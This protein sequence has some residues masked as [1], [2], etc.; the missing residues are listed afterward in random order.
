MANRSC[1]YS[2]PSRKRPHDH[3][4]TPHLPR[5]PL[6]RQQRVEKLPL[7]VAWVLR[8]KGLEIRDQEHFSQGPATLIERLRDYIQQCQAVV[9]LVGERC[10]TFPTDEHAAALGAVPVFDKSIMLSSRYHVKI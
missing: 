4:C 6:C 8:R 2:Q 5:L 1:G 9:L 3:D 7:E 10:G